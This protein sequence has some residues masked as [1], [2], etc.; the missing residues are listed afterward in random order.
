M[1]DQV[2]MPRFSLQERDQRW[3]RVRK[4]MA[5]RDL[6]CI[7][8]Y[9]HTGHNAQWEADSRYLGHCG[10]GGSS[11]ACVF[12]LEGDPTVFVLNRPEFWAAQQNWVADVRPSKRMVWSEP[13]IERL[14]ELGIDRHKIGISSLRGNLRATEGTISLRQWEALNEAFP[15]AAFEDVSI[16]MGQLRAVKSPEEI[17]TL[18]RA[19]EITRP[20]FTLWSRRPD[21]A[22][23]TTRSTPRSTTA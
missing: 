1:S 14:R 16:M 12:P 20:A 6:A 15:N 13:I 17:T 3:A 10:G 23:A 21:R 9:P 5:E 7:I 18:E 19:T 4:A 11:T 8:T 22:C 2:E